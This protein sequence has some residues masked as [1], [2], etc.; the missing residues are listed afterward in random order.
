[1]PAGARQPFFCRE[2][3]MQTLSAQYRFLPALHFAQHAYGAAWA[4]GTLQ[5]L[6]LTD[7]DSAIDM[8]ALDAV[9][10]R[11]DPAR[12]RASNLRAA[13]L[14]ATNLRASNLPRHQPA[15]LA[16]ACADG[17]CAS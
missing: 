1:L 12:R 2:H 3:V 6:V 17:V 11:L 7:D 8:A 16:R 15:R 9:L 4:N 13:S 14:H 5:W 10:R